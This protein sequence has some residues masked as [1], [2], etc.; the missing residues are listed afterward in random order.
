MSARFAGAFGNLSRDQR[1]L[2]GVAAGVV[3][4]GTVFKT[5]YFKLSRGVVIESM[6]ERHMKG[7]AHLQEAR[8]FASWAE[9]DRESRAPKL[10]PDQRRQLQDYLSIMAENNTEVFPQKK[11]GVDSSRPLPGAEYSMSNKQ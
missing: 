6:D 9:K 1:R 5:V 7:V 10:T 11:G 2:W 4:L 8:Q 3:V